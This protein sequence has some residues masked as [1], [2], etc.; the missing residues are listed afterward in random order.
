[1]TINL[2][3][4][5]FVFLT[6]LAVWFLYIERAILSPFVLGV[7]FAYIL[8]PVIN[9]FYRYIKLPRTISIIIIYFIIAGLFVYL[10]IAL[11]K[12]TTNESS[13]LK[14]F[15]SKLPEAT[16]SQINSLPYWIKPMAQDMLSFLE[17]PASISSASVF[18]FFPQAV[19]RIIS[20]F[21]FFFSGFYF[22]K[23]GGTIFGKLLNLAP[24][25]YRDDAESLLSKINSV[26][27]SYLRGQVFM[28]VLVSAVLYIAL[29]IVGVKFALILAIFSGFAEI[30]PIIGPI[31]AG[32]V[33]G[34][35]TLSST[36]LAFGLS[37][38]QGALVVVLIYF[39]FRQIQDYFIAPNIMGRIVRLHP[40]IVLF[41]VLAGQHIWGI[42]GV[43]LAVPIAGVIRILLQ[44]S[45]EKINGSRK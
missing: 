25:S 40:L 28:I 42:L 11:T 13:E 5:F 22:L 43:I 20:L 35:I 31:F 29:S 15:I 23:D 8:T 1:M 41:A 19:T 12:Q 36:N 33:G 14:S 17:R 10:G 27:K 38:L 26:L 9:F 7:I 32:A 37:N 45:L 16:E 44:F 18:N 4:A 3:T 30:I 24:K 21:I 34:L 6:I 39:I 2:R